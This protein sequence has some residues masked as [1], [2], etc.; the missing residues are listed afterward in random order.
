MK[1]LKWNI[2]KTNIGTNKIKI[3]NIFDHY[4]FSESV[5]KLLKNCKDKNE[6][7]GLLEKELIYYFW[8]K[9][10]YEITISSSPYNKENE[11]KIDIYSQIM[12]NYEIFVDYIWRNTHEKNIQTNF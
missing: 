7:K 4:K 5:E 8:C 11:E 1:N 6:F 10:E 12:N 3:F 2:Y 9:F